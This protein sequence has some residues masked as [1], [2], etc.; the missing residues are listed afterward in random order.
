MTLPPLLPK[1]WEYRQKPLCP[2]RFHILELIQIPLPLA[3]QLLV[4]IFSFKTTQTIDVPKVVS[5]AKEILFLCRYSVVA[6]AFALWFSVLFIFVCVSKVGEF[7]KE[8]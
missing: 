5:V 4:H 8:K 6:L 2:A 7:H 3:D 1:F